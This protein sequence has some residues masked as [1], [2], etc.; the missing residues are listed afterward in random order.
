MKKFKYSQYKKKAKFLNLRKELSINSSLF[1]KK[2]T[3]ITKILRQKSSFLL[4]VNSFFY[5]KLFSYC[6]VTG[7]VR[8]TVSKTSLSRQQFKQFLEKGFLPGFYFASW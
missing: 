4:D 2:N 1:L 3:V 7:R 8:F 6:L 5:S